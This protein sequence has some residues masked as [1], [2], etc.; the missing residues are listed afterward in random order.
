MVLFLILGLLIISCNQKA[1]RIEAEKAYIAAVDAYEDGQ[2]AESLD[3]VR[4][5]VT[6]DRNFY[7]ASFLEGKNLF[8]LEKQE[9]AE[10]IFTSLVSKHPSYTEARLWQ[11]RCLILKDDFATSQKLLDREDRKSVV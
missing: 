7:Q 9:E 3:L 4:T 2:F 11:I 8:F 5:A 6:L 10:R 1:R